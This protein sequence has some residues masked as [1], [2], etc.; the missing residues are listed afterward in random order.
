MRDFDR[1]N[2][3]VTGFI[4]IVFA[5]VVVYTAAVGYAIYVAS[6]TMVGLGTEGVGQKV[7]EFLKGIEKGRQ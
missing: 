4:L 2:R 3:L 5:L 7:G 1:M 6:D